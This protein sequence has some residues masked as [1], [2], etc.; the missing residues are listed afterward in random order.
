[1]LGP[2]LFLIFINDLPNV[3]KLSS[4]LFADDT[5]LALSS[6]NIQDL[7]TR[8]NLELDKVH[9]WLLA[10]G[11]SMHYKKKSQFMLIHGPNSKSANF[12]DFSFRVNMGGNQIDQ[13]E[14]YTYL[15]VVIDQKL[16][17]KPQI[18][19]LCSKLASVC[20]VLSKVRH[21]LDRK[22]LMKIYNSLFD[23]R[24]RYGLLGWGTASDSELSKIKVLQNRAV[25]FITFSSFRGKVAPLYSKLRILPLVDHLL[26]QRASFMHSLHFK[27]L[28]FALSAYCHQPQHRYSTRYATSLNYVLPAVATDRGKGSIKFSGPKA[29]AEVPKNLKE[30][31]FRKPFTKKFKEHILTTTYQEMPPK[32]SSVFDMDDAQFI[33]LKNLFQSDDDD[34]DDFLGFEKHIPELEEIFLSDD[35]T[36]NF[37]GFCSEQKEDLNMIF[38]TDSETEDFLGF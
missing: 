22:S 21:Y 9:D 24:L 15:G 34:E 35:E 20:G 18:K 32:S 3:S 10:N 16:S 17:W 23:S 12:K 14:S 27:S 11:L 4:W 28:P 38:L 33:E 6:K 19:Y 1:M 25:R 37:L 31:A 8:L 26:L 13:T 30:V 2:L 5:A 7:E 36:E 29:W